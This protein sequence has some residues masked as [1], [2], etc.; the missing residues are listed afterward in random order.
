M[1]EK[2]WEYF[3][4]RAA[5]SR[6]HCKRNKAK[7]SPRVRRVSDSVFVIS[8]YALVNCFLAI[9]PYIDLDKIINA[10]PIKKSKIIRLSSLLVP[11][12]AALNSFQIKM[13]HIAATIVAPCPSP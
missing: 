1:K 5:A 6:I 9:S 13:P 8:M 3:Y 10:S 4:K 12:G 7:N 2:V 11:F